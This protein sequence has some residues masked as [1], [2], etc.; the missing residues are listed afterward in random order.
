MFDVNKKYQVTGINGYGEEATEIISGKRLEE[1][2]KKAFEFQSR[3]ST[4]YMYSPETE[5]IAQATGF[6][7]ECVWDIEE[8]D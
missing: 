4:T 2:R 6:K 8:L 3:S 7:R 1:L 5:A